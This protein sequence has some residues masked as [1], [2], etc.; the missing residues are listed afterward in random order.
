MTHSRRLFL[1]LVGT[2][3]L[4]SVPA[5]AAPDLGVELDGLVA[6]HFPGDKPGAA[7]LVRKGE[8]ILLRRAYGKADLEGSLPLRPE[9]VF[10]LGSVTKQFTAVAIMTLVEEG[11]LS[12]RDDVRKFVPGYPAKSATITIEHLLTHTSGVPS[13]TDQ[14][15]FG[16]LMGK[17]L[18][19]TEL[20]AVFKDRPLDFAPGARWK[21]SNSGYYL[22]GLVIEKVSGQSYADFVRKRIFEPLQMAHSAYG[23]DPR[24][25]GRARGYDRQGDRVH[26]AQAI[27]MKPPF[28]AGALIS[29]VDDLARWDAAISS[30]RLLRKESWAKVFAPAK[31]NDGSTEP[32]GFGFALGELQGHPVQAHGGGIPGFATHLLRVPDQ[33]VLVVILCN[34]VP[35]P[36][37]LEHV[38]RQL[39]ALA[40]GQPIPDR[41]AVAIAGAVLEKYAGVYRAAGPDKRV[42][43]RLVDGH[44]NLQASGRPAL[45]ALAESESKF[46][47]KD[48]DLAFTFSRDA[49]GKTTAL[50]M[51]RPNGARERYART[52]EP[53]PLE[54]TTVSVDP[55]ILQRYVGNYA[56][57][58]DF[59]ISI[60]REGARLFAQATRQPRV[61]LFA[62]SPTRFF[63]KVVDAEV[64]F[65]SDGKETSIVLHQ[66][67]RDMPGKRVP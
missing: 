46:F 18:T 2:G 62:S 41:K 8:Q 24:I 34:S 4:A 43:V 30:G 1:A 36:I 25:A 57:A 27:S 32:Y 12:L 44:L 39:A 31:L 67:G 17:D 15:A 5:L 7:V 21:Y 37:P 23:D 59:V 56:L 9:S 48:T 16:A 20:L 6:P 3:A 64:T 61:E 13:Y 49:G 47:V 28:A 52:A 19:H 14:P 10:R 60:T 35:P 26:P 50:E 66:N 45:D 51:E 42:V 11:K 22:L 40:M 29:S 63:L 33:Q 53:L 65:R 54:R 55:E 38:A 58:P